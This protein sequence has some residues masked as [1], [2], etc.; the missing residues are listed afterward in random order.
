MSSQHKGS[1]SHKKIL[2]TILVLLILIIVAG[3]SYKVFYKKHSPPVIKQQPTASSSTSSSSQYAVS[4]PS[5]QYYSANLGLGF[6]YPSNWV[7]TDVS[8]SN[9]IIVTSNPLKLQDSN[10]ATVNGKI[11]LTIIGVPPSTINDYQSG[12][13]TAPLASQTINYTAPT[14]TQK[15]S[16]YISFLDDSATNNQ[17]VI[18][19]IYITGNSG[20]K[21]NQNVPKADLLAVSP[22]IYYSFESCPDSACTGTSKF[23]A[24][25]ASLWQN[26]TFSKP[27]LTMLESLAIN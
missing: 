17:N 1:I 18:N 20:Y 5:Q 15:A 7:V 12:T 27:L 25:P 6:N 26:Q 13:P 8:G 3:I 2:V 21:V 9:Q 11:V 10:G 14:Q 23:I 16:T 24:I 4:D 22:S 19:S